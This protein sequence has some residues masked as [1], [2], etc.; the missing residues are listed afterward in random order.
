M[1][2]KLVS[3]SFSI[4]ILFL[5]VSFN[6]GHYL[7]LNV[8]GR[9]LQIPRTR[10]IALVGITDTAIE[11]LQSLRLNEIDLSCG[12]VCVSS[13]HRW[14]V[15]C[16]DQQVVRAKENFP[17]LK[18]NR[19]KSNLRRA[20][21]LGS[22]AVKKVPEY[23][24]VGALVLIGTELVKREVARQTTFL[25]P[26]L[27][28]FANRTIFELDNKLDLLMELEFDVN[29]FIA[30][31]L[32]VLRTQPIEL[33]EK[34][35]NTE[36]ISKLEL[37]LPNILSVF[38]ADQTAASTLSNKIVDLVRLLALVLIKREWGNVE[39]GRTVKRSVNGGWRKLQN[40]MWSETNNPFTSEIAEIKYNH[41]DPKVPRI[42]VRKMLI[43]E[44]V[45]RASNDL[46]ETIN[47][48]QGLTKKLVD[49]LRQGGT[50]LEKLWSALQLPDISAPNPA[51]DTL[52]KL[53]DIYKDEDNYSILLFE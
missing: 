9:T 18:P 30:S 17:D 31:E 44:D 49:S 6:N 46:W 32:N 45:Q 20:Y 3:I 35:V 23:A 51:L 47:S 34:F 42:T 36:L 5:K 27:Q 15:H 29:P 11:K 26:V 7:R 50:A 22:K 4:F 37:L 13:V 25:P 40:R 8:F 53:F 24:L 43:S 41:V 38:I 10:L 16:R 48:N 14:E 39:L 28:D 2:C 52:N 19:N 21:Q 1:W 33:A 12:A